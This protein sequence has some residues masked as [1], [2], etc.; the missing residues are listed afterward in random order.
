MKK[1]KGNSPEGLDIT[2]SIELYK[3][4][5]CGDFLFNWLYEIY[6]KI[7]VPSIDSRYKDILALDKT[8][9]TIFDVLIDDLADNYKILYLTT[10]N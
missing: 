4:V 1:S 3:K 2:P 5:G 8:K 10:F 7:F 9:L 6:K